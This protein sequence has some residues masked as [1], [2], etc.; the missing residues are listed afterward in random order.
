MA[1][2]KPSYAQINRKN[3]TQKEKESVFLKYI[4]KCADC[5]QVSTR[6]GWDK[7]MSYYRKLSFYLGGLEIHHI[8]PVILGG[9]NRIKNL[10]LLCPECHKIRHG[11]KG[12]SNGEAASK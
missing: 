6:G 3:F 10:I 9:P 11:K 2:V 5:G 12:K 8:I 4:G 1:E 7:S